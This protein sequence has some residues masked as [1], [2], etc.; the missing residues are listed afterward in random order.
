VWF[1]V[2]SLIGGQERGGEERVVDGPLTGASPDSLRRLRAVPGRPRHVW[3][4]S[5][6]GV[7]RHVSG[8]TPVC[9]AGGVGLTISWQP[10]PY[11]DPLLRGALLGIVVARATDRAAFDAR[12]G[13]GVA[14]G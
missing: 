7:D 11:L 14:L 6:S 9:G 4:V 10:Y 2:D 13:R 1:L 5:S 12:R 3:I 8:G